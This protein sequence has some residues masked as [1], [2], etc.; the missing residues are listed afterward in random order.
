MIPLKNVLLINGVSSG[1]TG[2]GLITLSRFFAELFQVR[3][4]AVF[5]E[6]GVFLVVFSL[7]VIFQG[8]RSVIRAKSV[9]VIIALDILWV[10]ASFITAIAMKSGISPIGVFMIIAV[11]LWVAAMAYLQTKGLKQ[12][13]N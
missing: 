3:S 10:I 11:A 13:T 8:T 9:Q 4:S 7:F 6:V 1:A 2:L 12:S 5:T